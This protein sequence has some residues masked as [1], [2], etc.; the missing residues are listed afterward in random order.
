M[1][2][3]NKYDFGDFSFIENNREYYNHSIFF[4]II[5]N[6]QLWDYVKEFS[7]EDITSKK[8]N[9]IYLIF[10][11]YYNDYFQQ[12]DIDEY[13]DIMENFESIC[14]IGWDNYVLEYTNFD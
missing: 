4:R 11:N 3:E 13:I 14:H 7:S 12:L 2:S 6:Y 8:Y 1:N 10:E 9:N 5:N